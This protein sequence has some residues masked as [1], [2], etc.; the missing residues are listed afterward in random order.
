MGIASYRRARLAL[1]AVALGVPITLCAAPVRA[2]V[3]AYATAHRL[4]AALYPT[5]VKERAIFAVTGD[6]GAPLYLT[7]PRLRRFR[8]AVLSP[9]GALGGRE[10]V[11]GDVEFGVDGELV[12]LSIGDTAWLN[13]DRRHEI[14]RTMQGSNYDDDHFAPMLRAAGLKYG[15]DS[16]ADVIELARS[17]W[18]RLEPTLGTADVTGATFHPRLMVTW[19]VE[20]HAVR[21]GVA[22]YYTLVF[23]AVEGKSLGIARHEPR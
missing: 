10:I 20:V 6:E 13:A 2:E 3:D 11:A 1:L 21:E 7:E 22:S 17:T 4:F 12:G 18:A 5:L 9:L 14:Q 8:A 19:R 23:E 15:P 16:H